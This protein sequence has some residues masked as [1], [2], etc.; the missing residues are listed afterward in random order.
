MRSQMTW[1]GPSLLV[2]GLE[3][4][5]ALRV[6]AGLPQSAWFRLAPPPLRAFSPA[7]PGWLRSKCQCGFA[8]SLRSASS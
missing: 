4:A 3:L 1:V 8:R 7:E 6:V 2:L 5:L